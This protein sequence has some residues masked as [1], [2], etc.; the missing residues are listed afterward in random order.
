MCLGKRFNR[1]HDYKSV[2]R[3]AQAPDPIDE[4]T[5]LRAQALQFLTPGPRLRLAWTYT[6]DTMPLSSTRSTSLRRS[7]TSPD[8]MRPRGG[9]VLQENAV[10]TDTGIRLLPLFRG[11]AGGKLR[12]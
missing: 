10:V 7:L 3:L 12:Y 1:K 5:A 2:T 11:S 4:A 9:Y 8:E 6:L